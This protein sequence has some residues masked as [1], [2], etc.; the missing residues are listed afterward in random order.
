MVKN[1]FPYITIQI[2]GSNLKLLESN[3]KYEG[4]K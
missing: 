4:K 3:Q 2:P 1:Y